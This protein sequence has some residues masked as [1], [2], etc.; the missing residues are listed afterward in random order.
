MSIE[1]LKESEFRRT[2]HRALKEIRQ[3][4]NDMISDFYIKHNF[5]AQLIT[6]KMTYAIVKTIVDNPEL[7]KG[8]RE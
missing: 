2:H 7:I 4:A 1:I 3:K 5:E 8:M 6:R